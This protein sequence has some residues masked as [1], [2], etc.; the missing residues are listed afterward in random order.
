MSRICDITK[1]KSISG[2]NISRSKNKTK[3]KFYPNIQKKKF[4]IENLNIWV[5]LKVSTSI[6]R[7]INKNG[8]Y[9]VLKKYKNIKI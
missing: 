3:R 9:N 6:I 7:T 4:Y 1:K 5:K 8:I 2:N